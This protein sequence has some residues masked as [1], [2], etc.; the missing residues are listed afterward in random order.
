MEAISDKFIAALIGSH[1]TTARVEVLPGG[2]ET[3]RVD[4]SDYLTDGS[5]DVSRQ[6]I[7]RSGT[8]TFVDRDQS[9][10]IVPTGPDSLL[11]PY[12]NQLRVWAG[13]DFD[14]G[15]EE[16]V[17]VGTFRITRSVSRY[18]TCQ[19]DISDRAWVL[20]QAKLVKQTGNGK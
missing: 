17:C 11:A 1:Q 18:P 3:N 6:Q 19:V 16:L 7:R 12:G 13:I 9:G 14:D 10:L 8:L 20:Q 15:T 2:D 5:V 4:L